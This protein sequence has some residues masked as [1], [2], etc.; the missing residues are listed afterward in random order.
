[1]D[2]RQLAVSV[3]AVLAFAS[4]GPALAA[5]PPATW[6][7]LVKVKSKRLNYVYLLPGA[8]FR[9]Y[10][11]VILGPTQIAFKKNWQRD[12]NSTTRGLGARV[13]DEMVERT[14][15]DGGKA[16]S[17][18]FA[19]AFADGGYSI[20]T[21]PGADVLLIRTAVINLS[22][23]AP[24]TRSAGRSRTYA[25]EAG[26]ATLVVEA[27][28]SVSG[29]I[30]GRAVDSQV[31]GDYSYMINR[32]SM[33]NRSDF[34]LVAKE[35]ARDCVNGLGELKRLSPVSAAGSPP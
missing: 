27:V 17:E 24:D 28:D 9:A 5:S 20:V 31:A 14:I 10:T 33:T 25:G 4:A 13:T 2:R 32:N 19:K 1:M 34:A 3:I 26:S 23:T 16:A 7:D 11:K 22:I 15:A 29:A 21:E 18:I 12:Y 30:L 35:W 8:D 6:D